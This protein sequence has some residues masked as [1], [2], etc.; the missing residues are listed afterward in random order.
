M[1]TKTSSLDFADVWGAMVTE[2]AVRI[3]RER[4][5]EIGEREKTE[6]VRAMID[7]YSAALDESVEAYNA[8]GTDI[9]RATLN[10]S[11]VLTAIRGLRAAGHSFGQRSND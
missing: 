6:I 11:A 4:R 3:A 2:A 7:E 5:I 8:M 1:S 10:A 9:A